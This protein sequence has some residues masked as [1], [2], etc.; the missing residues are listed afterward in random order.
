MNCECVTCIILSY[1]KF[2]GL[3]SAIKSVLE[4]DYERI[5]VIVADDCSKDF[6]EEEILEFIKKHQKNN[7]ISIKILHNQQ[8]LGTVKNLNN[9]IMK[10]SGSI[11]INLSGDDL[12]YDKCTISKIVGI[13]HEE[14]YTHLICRRV[15]KS[16]N[17]IPSNVELERIE[18]V[19][20]AREQLSKFV[21]GQFNN[22]A[23]GC[24]FSYKK[25]FIIENGLYDDEYKL[26]EDGP[27]FYK[28]LKK[29][30]KI[31]TNYKIRSIV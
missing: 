7:L 20:T 13:M 25:D 12:F 22:L 2:N 21:I 17:F 1:N 4:Q 26:W 30:I 28:I 24:V 23:S 6:P 14:N 27:F 9:A 16:G 29:G 11:I 19:L 10:S 15:T 31:N 18:R 5:E 3:F 8:N